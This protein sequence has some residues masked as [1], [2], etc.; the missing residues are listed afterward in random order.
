MSTE[1]TEAIVT[2]VAMRFRI[3][4][5]KTVMVLPEGARA[6]E[7]QE[8]RIDNTMVKVIARA[9]RWQRLLL[10]GTYSTIDDLA[11]AENIN[12]SYVSRITRLALLSPTIVEAILE[13][14][15]PPD[16]TMKDLMT[17]FPLEWGAQQRLFFEGMPY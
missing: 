14:R 8:A 9:F 12:P 6:I 17:P 7:R 5:G 10:D 16:L 3:R 4:G 11:A 15:H 1:T 13:G 2:E